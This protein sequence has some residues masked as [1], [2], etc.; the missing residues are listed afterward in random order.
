[1]KKIDNID[2]PDADKSEWVELKLLMDLE[3]SVSKHSQDSAI[4]KYEC[5]EEWIKGLSVDVIPWDWEPD[6][7]NLIVNHEK[8]L[9]RALVDTGSDSSSILE[10]YTSD[11]FP[12]IKTDDRNTITWSTMGGKFAA[13]KTGNC[14]MLVTFSP[15][16]VQSQETKVYFLGV[17]SG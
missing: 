2:G 16:R 3:N 15:P 12:F 9:L 17:S 7:V 13:T 10:A 11:T 1:V 8:H 6:V 5:P 14:L 4:F